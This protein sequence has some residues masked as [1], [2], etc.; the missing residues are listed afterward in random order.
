MKYFIPAWYSSDKWWRDFTVPQYDRRQVSDFDDMMS[1]MHMYETND[2]AFQTLILNYQPDLRCFLHRHHLLEMDYWS[3]FDTIQGFSGTVPRA[4]SFKQLSFPRGTEFIY[5]SHGI[6]GFTDTG[7]YKVYYNQEGYLIWVEVYTGEVLEKRYVFDDRGFLSS[8]RVYKGDKL[9]CVKFMSAQGD[10]VMTEYVDDGLVEIM[11]DYYSRFKAQR[12]SNMGEVI[13]EYLKKYTEDIQAHFIVAASEHHAELA[14]IITKERLTYS[15]FTRRNTVDEVNHL[16]L[17]QAARLL[18]DTSANYDRLK[19]S[20]TSKTLKITPFDT[21]LSPTKS[22]EMYF[23]Y[24]GIIVDNLSDAELVTLMDTMYH[25]LKNTRQIKVMLISRQHYFR[26]TVLRD[27]MHEIN[28]VFIEQEKNF[29]DLLQEKIDEKAMIKLIEVPFEQELLKVVHGLR[30][31]VDLSTTPDLY[32]QIASISAGI[33]QIN[34]VATDYVDVGNNGLLID[35]IQDLPGALD[36]FLKT[37]K[38]WNK[39]FT[40][41]I[42]LSNKY[43]SAQIVDRINAFI[44]GDA[45]EREI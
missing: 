17:G 6:Q 39:A 4:L 42:E 22:S 31:I 24:I 34:K 1:F 33:P 41:S 38:H 28:Q 3:V 10:V 35:T 13:Y 9:Q 40:Y 8:V 12:Y 14:N 15:F 37:L 43:S 7:S 26:Q 45:N 32:L 19:G 16:N 44:E 11:P 36:H 20:V 29:E 21:S 25:Y 27:K 23:N 30:I 18:I 2:K 5:T